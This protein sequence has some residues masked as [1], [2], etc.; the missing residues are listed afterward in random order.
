MHKR[1]NKTIIHETRVFLFAKRRLVQPQKSLLLLL[2][3][4]L[5]EPVEGD[6]NFHIIFGGDGV[7]TNFTSLNRIQFAVVRCRKVSNEE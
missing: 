6:I 5:D 3:S 1:K 2:I 7:E 4:V